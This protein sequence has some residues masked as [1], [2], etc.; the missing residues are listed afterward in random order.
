MF[1]SRPG[2]IT[3]QKVDCIKGLRAK[4]LR[5]QMTLA[6]KI[7]WQAL[8]AK[9]LH[10]LHFR[11]Q[12]VIDGFIVDFYC[13]AASLVVEIDGDIHKLQPEYDTERDRVLAA[14]ELQIL[15]FQ[16]EEV[17]QDLDRVLAQI[18]EACRQS[19]SPPSLGEG[20]GERYA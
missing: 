10:G 14:R 1:R 20:W 12:Q 16:N 4:E 17:L 6:E 2:I 9:R 3:K 15:R 8:R 18:V 5:R 11:R 7:L 19:N 13:H